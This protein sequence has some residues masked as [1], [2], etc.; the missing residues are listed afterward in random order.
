MT[1]VCYRRICRLTQFANAPSMFSVARLRKI[2]SRCHIFCSPCFWGHAFHVLSETCSLSCLCAN[3]FLIL[4]KDT[5][6]E[7]RVAYCVQL[8]FCVLCFAN[9]QKKTTLWQRQHG[10][11]LHVRFSLLADCF[12]LSSDPVKRVQ[13]SAARG[14]GLRKP[15]TRL[16]RGDNQFL[17]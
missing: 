15:V 1:A 11:S 9:L 8:S 6:H 7:C 10:P 16:G 5:L 4:Y 13:M 17:S 12:S 14:C 2:S 3:T